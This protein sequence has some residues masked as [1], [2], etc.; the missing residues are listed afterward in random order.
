MQKLI[1]VDG[2]AE[3]AELEDQSK[4]IKF[5]IFI[6]RAII[7]TARG[8]RVWSS[9]EKSNGHNMVVIGTV[10]YIAVS[11]M[12]PSDSVPPGAVTATYF[13]M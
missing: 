1:I 3:L 4:K 11:K 10:D 8:L 6:P 9:S 7:E 5:K 2:L 12:L 13:K